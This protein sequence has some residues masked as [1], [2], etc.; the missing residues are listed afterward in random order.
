MRPELAIFT[1]LVS[2]FDCEPVRVEGT[3]PEALHGALL[4]NGPGQQQVGTDRLHLLDGHSFV[5]AAQFDHGRLRIIGKHTDS[6]AHRGEQGKLRQQ[7]RYVFTNRPGGMLANTFRLAIANSAAHDVYGFGG[8]L[9]A[10]DVFGHYALEPHDLNTVGS[11]PL[12]ALLT[13]PNDQIS[14]MPRVHPGARVL[15]AYRF[16]PGVFGS[17]TITLF[18]LNADG[19]ISEGREHEL[20]GKGQALHDLAVTDSH[21]VVIRWGHLALGPVLLGTQALGDA[22][23]LPQAETLVYLLPRRAGERRWVVR[24]PRQ[25]IFHLFNAFRRGDELVIDVVA[26]DEGI[27]FSRIHPERYTTG[28]ESVPEVRRHSISLIDGSVHTRTYAANGEAPEVDARR[29]GLSSRYGYVAA[30]D[31]SASL[32]VVRGAYFWSNAVLKVDFESAAITRWQAP[33]DAFLSPPAFVPR[34]DAEDDGYV[35]TWLSN[36]Q[37]SAVV[38]LDAQNLER[39]PLATAW[40]EPALPGTSHTSWYAG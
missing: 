29:H 7:Q 3:I 40:F 34:G 11:S 26:Y 2:D 14:P 38:V 35:L 12:N 15:T 13:K 31:R 18:E 19:T 1:N 8:K 37:Q 30:V 20:E 22:I 33:E 25:Q 32:P 27:D 28:V 10:A 9:Y 16:R 6:K 21:D 5:V 23:T 39:G 24:L 4:R 36:G 17:D